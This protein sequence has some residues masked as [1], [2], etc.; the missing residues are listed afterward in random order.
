VAFL[1]AT[2]DFDNQNDF[3]DAHGE[4]VIHEIA[5]LC[6]CV[7]VDDFSLLNVVGHPE[8]SCDK[9]EGLGYFFR[10]P[11]R[12]HGL[13]T[14]V[15]QAYQTSDYSVK[16]YPGDC[17]FSPKI[18][19]RPISQYDKVTFTRPQPLSEGQLI[20]RGAGTLGYNSGYDYGLAENEDRL[21][22][23]ATSAIHVEA[24]DSDKEFLEGS[25]FVLEGK[26]IRWLNEAILL[27]TRYVIKYNAKLEWISLDPPFERRE[28]GGELGQRV[29]LR[30]VHIFR[31]SNKDASK[32]SSERRHALGG[33][34][35]E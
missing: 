31:S 28:A 26:V 6:P 25:D 30:K 23:E 8:M 12:I 27:R 11:K 3:I 4:D 20:T 33:V 5:L 29:S 34:S 24:I 14:S 16:M 17:S 2:F 1:G 22:Y 18:C 7:G 35:T 13:V 15:T 10:K 19:E 32:D 9:C 21:W